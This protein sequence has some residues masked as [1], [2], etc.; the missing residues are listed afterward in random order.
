MSSLLNIL[1][2]VLLCSSLRLSFFENVRKSRNNNW[3]I[4]LF[5][6]GKAHGQPDWPLLCSGGACAANE[7]WSLRL[8]YTFLCGAFSM[9]MFTNNNSL[10]FNGW[11]SMNHFIMIHGGIYHWQNTG[12]VFLSQQ[13]QLAYT[14]HLQNVGRN[15]N[16]PPVCNSQYS[17][18]SSGAILE[19]SCQWRTPTKKTT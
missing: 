7:V 11:I 5:P 16:G 17:K 15:S 14:K 9:N 2:T 19:T 13:I 10:G 4:T 1:T 12:T 18:S 6:G 3:C 8:L